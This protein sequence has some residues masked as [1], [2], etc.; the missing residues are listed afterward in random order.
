MK[1]FRQEFQKPVRLPADGTNAVTAGIPYEVE[2]L[3]VIPTHSAA[4][5]E[6][7][8]ANVAGVFILP[9]NTLTLSAGKK[10]YWNGSLVKDTDGG[11][12]DP[13]IGYLVRDAAPGDTECLVM[14][15][16]PGR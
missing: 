6:E 11:S 4:K 1:N 10:A 13:Q 14:V 15:V 7:F 12:G 9:C 2:D 5:D 8:E 16:P 3:W